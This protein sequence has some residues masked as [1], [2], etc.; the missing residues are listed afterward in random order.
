MVLPTRLRMEHTNAPLLKNFEQP[1]DQSLAHSM[2]LAF[3]LNAQYIEDS[4]G[5]LVTELAALQMGNGKSP[6][7]AAWEKRFSKNPRREWFVC[8]A[9]IATTRS[10]SPSSI[11][12][13]P[14]ASSIVSLTHSRDTLDKAEAPLPNPWLPR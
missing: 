10:R 5:M 9:S 11:N 4:D 2:V 13:I 7:K 12:R 14:D 1:A 8:N 6:Q 3:A